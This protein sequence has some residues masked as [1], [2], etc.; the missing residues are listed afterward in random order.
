MKRQL[1]TLEQ[2]QRN[3][4]L[5]CVDGPLFASP[6][7]R[8]VF[9]QKQSCVRPVRATHMAAGPPFRDIAAQCPAGLWMVSTNQIP[10]R[11]SNSKRSGQSSGCLGFWADKVPSLHWSCK[12][13][14]FR[15]SIKRFSLCRVH[16]LSAQPRSYGRFCWPWQRRPLCWACVTG[17]R[18][19]MDQTFLAPT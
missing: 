8:M 2:A 16:S 18:Q 1:R 7:P 5:S 6:F 17:C 19:T 9:R 14:L 15:W 4:T 10:F 11:I 13:L 12:L 3:H